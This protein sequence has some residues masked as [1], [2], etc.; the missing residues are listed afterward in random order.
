MA[1]HRSVAAAVDAFIG[2]G[3][4]LGDRG[5][6]IDRAFAE[7]AALPQ[8]TLVARSSHYASAPIDAPGGE[9]LNAVAQVKTSLAPR[10]LLHAM[11]GIEHR[12]GR[13]RPFRGAPRTLDLDLLLYSDLVVASEELSI[14]HPRLHERAFVLAP[15]L[16]VAPHLVVPGRGALVELLGKVTTQP[17]AK[18]DR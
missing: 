5:A 3:S 11:Q 12:H 9:Y 13:A 2:L 15:L 6:E 16:E 14:P 4:N 17:V 18:L 7:I 10:E 1:V 8:T